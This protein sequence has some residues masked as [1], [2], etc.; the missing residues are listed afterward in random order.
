MNSQKLMN[1]GPNKLW[2]F[3]KIQILTSTG[4]VIW[5]VRVHCLKFWDDQT[6]LR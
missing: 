5:H 4:D 6:D 3:G 2:G 1:S